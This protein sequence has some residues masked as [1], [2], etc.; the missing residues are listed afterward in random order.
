MAA[1]INGMGHQL[2]TQYAMPDH[3]HILVAISMNMAPAM[4]LQVVKGETSHWINEQQLL[5]VH[6]EWQRGYR[7]LH[8]SGDRISTVAQYIKRQ[9]E[10]HGLERFLDEDERLMREEGI[11]FNSEYIFKEPE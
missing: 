3:A 2:I 4:L 9:P 11:D 5:P 1:K 7:W 8:V 10:H 6:F